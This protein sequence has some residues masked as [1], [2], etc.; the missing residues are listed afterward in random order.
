MNIYVIQKAT[1]G[2]ANYLLKKYKNPSAAIAYDSR[3]KS[4]LF[5]REAAKVLAGNGIK[6]YIYEELMPTPALSFAVRYLKCQAGI[7]VTAVSYTHLPW[8]SQ[9]FLR[10]F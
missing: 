9:T 5:A 4:N 2:L 6:V 8:G 3:I 10:S 1:Q 7:C